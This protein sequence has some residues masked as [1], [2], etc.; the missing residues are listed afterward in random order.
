M[1]KERGRGGARFLFDFRMGETQVSSLAVYSSPSDRG[2]VGQLMS[3]RPREEQ[4]SSNGCA[5]VEILQHT[6][7][8][9]QVDGVQRYVCY[10][11]PRMFRMCVGQFVL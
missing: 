8:S 5:L 11:I 9:E 6:C 3:P 7:P 2:W 1:R 10:P 4:G